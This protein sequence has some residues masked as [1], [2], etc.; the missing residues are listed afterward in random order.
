MKSN[1]PST[2]TSQKMKALFLITLLQKTGVNAGQTFKNCLTGAVPNDNSYDSLLK[3]SWSNDTAINNGWKS[4]LCCTRSLSECSSDTTSCDLNSATKFSCNKLDQEII[5]IGASNNP[6]KTLICGGIVGDESIKAIASLNSTNCPD[7]SKTFDY[8]KS[9]KTRGLECP[10]GSACENYGCYL[11]NGGWTCFPNFDDIFNLNNTSCYLQFP[12]SSPNDIPEMIGIG[13]GAAGAGALTAWGVAYAKDHLPF[14]LP[15]WLLNLKKKDL[16]KKLAKLKRELEE[17]KI[18]Y[19]SRVPNYK[20]L[21]AR[22]NEILAEAGVSINDANRIIGEIIGNSEG[23]LIERDLEKLRELKRNIVELEERVETIKN[24]VDIKYI[25]NNIET[26]H[27]NI[28]GIYSEGNVSVEGDFL[29]EQAK[30][31]VGVN[32]P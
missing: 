14:P 11:D 9:S 29:M 12:S 26:M 23:M 31:E 1:L 16:R 22:L 25:E 13:V 4:Q 17:L 3:Y 21:E 5:C 15:V 24:F 18:E 28:Q 10:K 27:K 19:V 7:T 2:L 30:I 20:E 8:L 6:S 32:K